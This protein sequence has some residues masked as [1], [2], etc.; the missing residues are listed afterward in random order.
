M[1]IFNR[2]ILNSN[3]VKSLSNVDELEKAKY[4]KREGGP[5]NYKYYYSKQDYISS[6]AAEQKLK[7]VKTNSDHSEALKTKIKRIESEGKSTQ[8]TKEEL[9]LEKKQIKWEDSPKYRDLEYDKS[10]LQN[11][12]KELQEDPDN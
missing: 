3:L 7:E 4:Y 5:G 8:E 2:S 10:Q 1:S 11:D 12:K 6:K 9:A